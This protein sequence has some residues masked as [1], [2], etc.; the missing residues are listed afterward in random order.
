MNLGDTAQPVTPPAST[1]RLRLQGLSPCP[2]ALPSHLWQRV[3][4]HLSHG[5]T[6]S[7]QEGCP[8]PGQPPGGQAGSLGASLV[9]TPTLR[10][11]G[12]L[13]AL[14]QLPR[15]LQVVRGRAGRSQAQVPGWQDPAG[16]Q[17][18]LPSGSASFRVELGSAAH[19]PFDPG[20]FKQRMFVTDLFIT[21]KNLETI[22]VSSA[23]KWK[24]RPRCIRAARTVQLYKGTG[25]I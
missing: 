1:S 11:W 16:P 14:R 7:P 3:V 5:V 23:G 15:D 9:H 22:R 18:S 25:E 2:P 13:G 6:E 4:E 24:N 20:L 12:D 17:P 21:A 10:G 19:H 8:E